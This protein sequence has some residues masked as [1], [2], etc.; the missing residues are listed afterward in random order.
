MSHD[1]LAVAKV[2]KQTDAYIAAQC[3]GFTKQ[4]REKTFADLVAACG[5]DG[6]I[7][8]FKNNQDVIELGITPVGAERPPSNADLRV[9]RIRDSPLAVFYHTTYPPALQHR[10]PLMW[11]FYIGLN[12]CGKE[13]IMLE[14]ERAERGISLWTV[15]M[16]NQWQQFTL[17]QVPPSTRVRVEYP[18]DLRTSH[19]RRTVELVFPDEHPVP[20]QP[21]L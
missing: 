2:P 4:E 13:S 8:F 1:D 20:V 14:E 18:L 15:N 3:P 10:G 17:F 21:L 12:G 11:T 16:T 6:A 19:E 7:A 9:A 5:F